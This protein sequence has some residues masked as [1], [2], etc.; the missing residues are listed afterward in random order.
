MRKIFIFALTLL[1][2]ASFALGVSATRTMPL[3][4]DNANLLTSD[5]EI[6]LTAMLENISSTQELEIAIVTVNSTG[7]RSA[8]DYADD[9]YDDNGYGWGENDDG[10]LLLIDMGGREWWITT[11]GNGAYYLDDYTLYQIENAFIDDLAAGNYYSAFCTFASLC[12]SYVISAKYAP[13]SST[14]DDYNTNAAVT[15]Y[16]DDDYY[17]DYDYDEYDEGGFSFDYVLPAII[18]G[19]IVSLIMVSVMKSGMKSV[20]KASGAS[21]Y[22]VSGSLNL[23]SQSDRF[24][25]SNTVRTRRDT[26]SNSGG[27]SGSRGGF[28]GGSSMHRSS[29]GRSHGGRGGRF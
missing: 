29:S 26:S 23:R 14:S 16:W 18:V 7:G 3:V 5:E 27:H 8:I 24:L 11:H 13:D 28:G 6:A 25:Y 1:V 19:F 12:E 21:D 2:I 10:A 17:Y 20:R 15:T 9:F 22:I 4:V